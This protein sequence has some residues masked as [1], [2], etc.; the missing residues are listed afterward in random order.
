MPGRPAPPGTGDAVRLL[1]GAPLLLAVLEAADRVGVQPSEETFEVQKVGG[2]P[3][4]MPSICH[5]KSLG[6]L[7]EPTGL[8]ESIAGA[9]APSDTDCMPFHGSPVGGTWPAFVAGGAQGPD[10]SVP[11][12]NA[13][14][15]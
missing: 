8:P 5:R 10:V 14:S 12:A 6:S 9:N 7:I 1:A 15:Q 11:P 2:P 13:S 4:P 3:P